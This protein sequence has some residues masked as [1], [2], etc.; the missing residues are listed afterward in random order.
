MGIF[1]IFTSKAE[2]RSSPGPADDFW[3][4]LVP[5]SSKT[6][7]AKRVSVAKA[8]Q[9]ASVFACQTAICQSIAMLPVSVLSEADESR[10]EQKKDHPLWRILRT[11]PNNFMDRFTFFDVMQRNL[12]TGNAYA[13][14]QR[15]KIGKITALIP[16]ESGRVLPKLDRGELQYDYSDPSGKKQTYLQRD[17]FH[18]RCFSKDG[19]IGRSPLEVACE[20]VGEALALQEHGNNTF[21]NGAYM[22]GVLRSPNAIK[23]KEHRDNIINSFKE[24]LG[25]R[26][27]GKVALLES[28]LEFKEIQQT[29]ANAQFVDLRRFSVEQIASIHRIPP[30]F[31][32]HM[33]KGMSYASVEQLAIAFVQY[34]IQPWV[35][36]WESG[37]KFQ[38]LDG[39]SDVDVSARFNIS[40]LIRG[41]LASRTASVVSQLQYGL[42]TINEGRDLLDRNAA[43]DDVANKLLISHNLIPAD[44]VGKVP[45]GNI[46]GKNPDS[47]GQNSA[48]PVFLPVMRSIF[49]RI[50][51]RESRLIEK[52][53]KKPEFETWCSKFLAEHRDVV[54]ENLEPVVEAMEKADSREFETLIDEYI[55][56]R[57]ELLRAEGKWQTDFESWASRALNMLAGTSPEMFIEEN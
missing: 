28:G 8:E 45:S 9:L 26:N 15:D 44:M 6:S 42:L 33:D 46:G 35:T 48:K 21:E 29:N 20:T 16:L 32:Q 23:D 3:F 36:L 31:I 12:F 4:S 51:T 54:R 34:T 13:F 39:N 41:D 52:A 37:I 43:E 30:Q 18:L 14:I 25:I 10:K 50:N 11:H 5:G 2:K 22:T 17:I 27:A 40:A 53:R 55:S 56:E 1:S 57:T 7:A 24:F 19:I 38:L 49:R 47:V